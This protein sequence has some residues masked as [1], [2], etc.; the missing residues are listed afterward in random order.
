MELAQVFKVG[1]DSNGKLVKT[2]LGMSHGVAQVR[3]SEDGV[4]VNSCF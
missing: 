3:D 4:A 2:V 1:G